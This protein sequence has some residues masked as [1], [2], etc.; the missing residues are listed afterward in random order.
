MSGILLNVV[1]GSFTSVPGAPTIGAATA[2]Y[3][4]S[5]TVS[6]T[7]PA[8]DGG[9]VITSYT[10]TSTPD[11]ITG[12]LSQA[13]SG[14][15]TVTGLTGATSYT[16]TVTATNAIG[17][18]APSSASNSI[19]TQTAA[20]GLFGGGQVTGAANN[21]IDYINISS[22]G[23]A[24]DFGD[25]TVARSVLGSCA[26][27]TRGVWANGTP[28]TDVIDYVT[29]A[30]TGNATDFGDL[31]PYTNNLAGCSNSTRGL[32]AGGVDAVGTFVNAIN[33]ITIAS[34]GNS[35]D[36]GDLLVKPSS[37]ASCASTTRGIFAG[38]NGGPPT[39]ATINNINFVTIAS[40]GNATDFG[41]LYLTEQGL[42]GCSSSTRGLFGGGTIGGSGGVGT[43][44][45]SFITI[46]S[47]GNSIDFGDLTAVRNL[48]AGCSDS[49]RG[50][51][52]GGTQ[53]TGG[54][55]PV[56][57]MDFVTIASAGNATDFGDLFVA[58]ASLA[59]CSSGHGGI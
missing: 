54:G 57:V 14:T 26:S 33:F 36:F 53:P 32:F 50:V 42:A 45:I 34:T 6:Y 44:V 51:F 5:A 9:S 30:T 10:A 43:N 11:S 59:G 3:V 21:T 8:S 13:G 38:G 29:I 55:A 27:S 4:T 19:T 52:A 41:D 2:T 22:A 35:T 40:A 18:S 31:T 20:R 1:G 15:I 47:T 39:Y 49:T 23:N 7:A 25:L 17:T 58:R 48:N 37:L 56:N 24:T 46:A 16:F 28:T 12:T